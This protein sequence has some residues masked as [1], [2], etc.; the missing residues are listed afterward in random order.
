MQIAN[1]AGTQCTRFYVC[2]WDFKQEVPFNDA[3]S[4]YNIKDTNGGSETS[5]AGASGVLVWSQP[6][7]M[8]KQGPVAWIG[9][10][11]RSCSNYRS[12]RIQRAIVPDK[13]CAAATRQAYTC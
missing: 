6:S 2:R 5:F 9:A 3:E 10:A 13:L 7:M 4:H 12:I 1:N 11:C 8:I